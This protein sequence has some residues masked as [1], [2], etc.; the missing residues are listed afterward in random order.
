LPGNGQCSFENGD[1]L[2]LGEIARLLKPGGYAIFTVPAGQSKMTLW[3]R[4][5]SPR[6]L[7]LLFADWD[8]EISY[9]AHDG[10]NYKSVSEA[11]VLDADYDYSRGAGAIAGIIG[12]PRSRH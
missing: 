10:I 1:R 12:R 8:I 4:Q 7:R 6:D 11:D 5:Y 9:W 2:A 3:Y